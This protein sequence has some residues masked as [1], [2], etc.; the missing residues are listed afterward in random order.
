MGC[1]D[2]R[3]INRAGRLPAFLKDRTM[4]EKQSAYAAAATNT[5]ISGGLSSATN[6]ANSTARDTPASHIH[7]ERL[8]ASLSELVNLHARLSNIAN[9]ISGP[10]PEAAE[11]AGS[12][13]A[14]PS[15][16]Q[17]RLDA[18]VNVFQRE[19]GLMRQDIERIERFV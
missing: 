1:H 3:L 2:K 6:Q 14:Q 5:G 13:Q 15:N 17:D 19:L 8:F 16:L 4:Y 11:G 10:V 9:R 12:A 18:A 7:T